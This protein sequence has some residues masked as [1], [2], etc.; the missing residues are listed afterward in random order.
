MRKVRFAALVLVA[1][2]VC[3]LAVFASPDTIT[4]DSTGNSNGLV[5]VTKPKNQK[6]STFNGSYIISGYGKEGTT[7][8]LYNYSADEGVYKKIFN[9]T[10]FVDASGVRQ[11]MQTAA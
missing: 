11:T 9:E 2:F 8:T 5:V 4:T 10:E 7:V 6:D 3:Q 1:I